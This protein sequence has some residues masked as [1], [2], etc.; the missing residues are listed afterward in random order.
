MQLETFN[1]LDSGEAQRILQGC[2]HIPT[3]ISELLQQRPYSSKE[4][5]YQTALA[6]AQTWQWPEIS[7]ALSQ[8]PRIGEK[9]AAAVLSEKEQ[10]FSQQE[11][12]QIQ[13]DAVLQLALYQGNLDYEQKFGH[14]YLIRAAGRSG[15][16]ILSELQ[17]RLKNTAE[18]ER[19]EVKQQL[20]EIALL[21]LNQEIQ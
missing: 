13:I 11:Q 1:Q 14:I 19:A 9:K 10:Q 21:R 20:G 18:Q 4:Q 12:G 7:A 16:Q 15:Q 8:H 17:R 3:W 2:V 6:Q 5:L